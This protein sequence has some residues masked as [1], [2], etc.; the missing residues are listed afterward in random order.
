MM[1]EGLLLVDKPRGPTSFDVVAQVRRRLGERKVGHAGTLD[2]LAT[3]LLPILVGE[4]T[5][6]VGHLQNLDKVYFATLSLGVATDSYD[7][8]GRT[9]RVAADEEMAAVDEAAVR[10]AAAE[11]VGRIKQRPPVYSA[12]KRD[13][14]RLYELARAGEEVIPDEREVTVHAITVERVALPEVAFTVRCG[15]GT[16]VRSLA[17]DL[18]ARLGVGAHL[19]A[20]RRTRI[21]PLDVAD[22][23]DVFADAPDA[24]DWPLRPLADA[25]GHLPALAIDGETERRLRLGQQQPLARLSARPGDLAVRLLR[26]GRL[27]AVAE[28]RGEGWALARVFAVSS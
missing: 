23:I 7:A 9:T 8:E 1:Q 27:V 14:K 2:P 18:G 6:L 12:L 26:D 19:T 5:K 3:G 22:A 13:G 4:G 11:L 20:L 15:K 28:R 16:Y 25:V 24:K 21:G 10:R 17:H